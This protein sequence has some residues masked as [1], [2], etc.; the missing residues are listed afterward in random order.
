[1]QVW[2]FMINGLQYNPYKLCKIFQ[3]HHYKNDLIFSLFSFLILKKVKCLDLIIN[4]KI[5][6]FFMIN[7]QQK[8]QNLFDRKK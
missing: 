1:M 4:F 6:S 8:E 3:T 5:E 2:L 7:R